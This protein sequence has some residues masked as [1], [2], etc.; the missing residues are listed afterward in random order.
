MIHMNWAT[1]MSEGTRYF[2]LSMST[3]WEPETFSTITCGARTR[4]QRIWL[5]NVK[6]NKLAFE[7]LRVSGVPEPLW[8]LLGK[9][10]LSYFTPCVRNVTLWCFKAVEVGHK[11]L[12][13]QKLRCCFRVNKAAVSQSSSVVGC[14]IHKTETW[15]KINM[16]NHTLPFQRQVAALVQPPS[17]QHTVLQSN[18]HSNVKLKILI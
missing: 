9:V 6:P 5:L 11:S 10:A 13:P 3:I 18:W 2:L 15:P 1:V 16:R 14:Q 17:H 8:S 4:Q 12:F 7:Q